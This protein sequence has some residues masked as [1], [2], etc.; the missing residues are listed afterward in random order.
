METTM[1][2]LSHDFFK[3]AVKFA[4]LE[5]YGKPFPKDKKGNDQLKP[6][7]RFYHGIMHALGCVELIPKVDKLYRKHVSDYPETMDKIA[8]AFGYSTKELLILVQ[9]AALFHDTGRQADGIDYWDNDSANIL[10]KYLTDQDIPQN[11]ATLLKLTIQCKDNLAEF[12]REAAEIPE[13]NGLEIDYLRHLINNADTFEVIR[14]RKQF[15]C[16]Y[17]QIPQHVANNQ[18]KDQDSLPDDITQLVVDTANKINGEYRDCFSHHSILNTKKGNLMYDEVKNYPHNIDNALHD[19]CFD[20]YCNEHE[21]DMNESRNVKKTVDVAE[22]AEAP[23]STKVFNTIAYIIN[24][25]ESPNHITRRTS[26]VGSAKVAM[27]RN[28]QAWIAQKKENITE[29]HQQ[30]NLLKL[31]HAICLIKRNRVHFWKTPTSV[32]ELKDDLAN[33]GIPLPAET[34]EVSDAIQTALKEGFI[35]KIDK[36]VFEFLNERN[37]NVAEL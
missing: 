27:L 17:L 35:D 28:L 24:A 22:D 8:E 7:N 33:K 16:R 26:G 5:Y 25:I 11:L 30:E 9:T 4:Y 21:I 2:R 1:P 32:T 20:S 29:I 19:E 15:E 23:W 3:K 10:Y 36:V 34:I 18:L 12:K 37:G 13:I 31:I 6:S 14:V